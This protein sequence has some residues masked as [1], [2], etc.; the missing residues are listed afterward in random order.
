MKGAPFPIHLFFR[1]SNWQKKTGAC[2]ESSAFLGHK[3]ADPNPQ[4]GL[5]SARITTEDMTKQA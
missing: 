1:V 5:R 3:K 4:C 2:G